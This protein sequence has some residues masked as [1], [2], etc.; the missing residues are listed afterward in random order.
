MATV[1]AVYTG[2]AYA[3]TSRAFVTIDVPVP[4]G[5]VIVVAEMLNGVGSGDSVTSMSGLDATWT[6]VPL[7][8]V[9]NETFNVWVGIGAS[10]AGTIQGDGRLLPTST[11]RVLRAYVVTGVTGA[12]A[13]HANKG[14]NGV[15]IAALPSA[16]AAGSFV[17]AG[18]YS[19]AAADA[20]YALTPAAGWV[21]D[22]AVAPVS[23]RYGDSAHRIPTTSATH[24]VEARRASSGYAQAAI[25][26]L[27]PS[28][29]PTPKT[30][31]AVLTATPGGSLAL[32]EVTPVAS[33]AV[34]TATPGGAVALTAEAVEVTS[35]AV[36]T[37]TPGGSL[38]LAQPGADLLSSAVLTATPSGS[39]DLVQAT[40]TPP[41]GAILTAIPGGVLELAP[42]TVTGGVLTAT[43]G[44]SLWLAR[45]WTKDPSTG[46]GAWSLVASDP[47]GTRHVELKGASLVRD[48]TQRLNDLD[49]SG[50]GTTF[51]MPRSSKLLAFLPQFGEVQLYRGG[52]HLDTFMLLRPEE[53]STQ[54][55]LTYRAV[56]LGWHLKK[57]RIGPD[58]R[59]GLL[60]KSTWRGGYR[61]GSI[62][63]KAPKWSRVREPAQVGPSLRVE[64]SRYVQETVTELPA[65][66]TFEPGSWTLSDTGKAALRELADEVV[67]DKDL[68]D[69]VDIADPVITVEG[70]TD[71]VPDYGEGGNQGLSERRAQ[72]VADYLAQYVPEGTQFIVKGYGATVPKVKNRPGGTVE[73]RRVVVSYPKIETAR[74]HR[75]YVEGW[76]VDDDAW[77]RGER[78]YTNPSRHIERNLTVVTWYQLESYKEPNADRTVLWIGRRPV[79]TSKDV[80]VKGSVRLGEWDQLIDDG[81]R[82]TWISKERHRAEWDELVAE[83]K[84]KPGTEGRVYILRPPLFDNTWVATDYVRIDQ[85]TP[86]G[87]WVRAEATI[88]VPPDGQAWEILVRLTP[89]AGTVIY[90]EGATDVYADDALEFIDVDQALIVKGLIEHAQDPAYGKTD[91]HLDTRTPLTGVKRRRVYYHHHRQRI[92][93]CLAELTGLAD[94]V[95]IT[96]DTTPTSRRVRTHYPRAGQDTDVVLSSHGALVKKWGLALDGEQTATTGIVQADGSGPDREEGVVRGRPVEGHVF[97]DVWTAEPETHIGELRAQARTAVRRYGGHV[98]VVSYVCNPRFTDY[99]LDRVGLGDTVGQDTRAAL[100]TLTG[101]AR[102][103]DRAI[104]PRTDQVTYNPTQEV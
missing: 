12:V 37:A 54:G 95:D 99:L 43:P 26:E 82:E 33:G 81:W 16:P 87:T 83:G 4:A 88:K 44:G 86:L 34:L 17:L 93:D 39:L 101:R 6:R 72:A 53:D 13:Q 23:G 49:G 30:S 64:G 76:V 60:R 94:G 63:A 1:Y 96:I 5:A 67:V 79:P 73:N 42:A 74:G 32:V 103:E 48:I 92:S 80:I 19:A 66:T 40:P 100:A 31:G 55:V 62:P 45:D 24:S 22:G 11:G 35:G 46:K 36:L 20:I 10:G 71:D 28:G 25:V 56:G 97:E 41:G 70:H 59:P 75:Q 61:A 27:A 102:V 2:A 38:A 57:R 84:I 58:R 69:L 78:T 98:P 29:T 77:E 7:T 90:D 3:G 65:G 18:G 14:G 15:A 91:L 52:H 89:P 104:N 9:A 68:E 51:T 8:S 47:D 85:E 50:S 21:E